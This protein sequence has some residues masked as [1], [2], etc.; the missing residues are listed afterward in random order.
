[1]LPELPV[2]LAEADDKRTTYVGGIAEA[3]GRSVS[4]APHWK[5]LA[6]ETPPRPTIST[7]EIAGDRQR[8][9]AQ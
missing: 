8:A 9:D 2:F 3:L 1:L 6:A 7:L 4:S 5:R